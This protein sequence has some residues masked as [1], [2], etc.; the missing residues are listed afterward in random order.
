M[1]VG[2]AMEM[3]ARIG[4]ASFYFIHQ[5]NWCFYFSINIWI[6]FKG[7]ISNGM[8]IYFNVAFKP[9]SV[10]LVCQSRF[11]CGDLL[12]AMAMVSNPEAHHRSHRLVLSPKHVRS[13]GLLQERY[14]LYLKT[15]QTNLASNA[16]RGCPVAK[17]Y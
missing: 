16:V 9:N 1:L 3:G 5:N 2:C 8:D 10:Q 4:G 17:L 11:E 7:G 15:P 14:F 6:G 12:V 13:F